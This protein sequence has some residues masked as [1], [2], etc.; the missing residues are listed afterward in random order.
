[1]ILSKHIH[2]TRYW[3]DQLEDKS[4]ANRNRWRVDMAM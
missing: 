2:R 3:T 4:L 1:M